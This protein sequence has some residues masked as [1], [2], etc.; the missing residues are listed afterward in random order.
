MAWGAWMVVNLTIEEELQVEALAR[1]AISHPE[2]EQIAQMCASLVRQ[3]AYQKK[4]LSQAVSYISE[5]EIKN[6]LAEDVADTPWRRLLSG[7]PL[8]LVFG[9]LKP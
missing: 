2:H 7:N 4:M 1:S 3:N 5:L 8:A 9:K 6:A